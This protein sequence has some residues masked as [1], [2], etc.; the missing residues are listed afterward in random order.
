MMRWFCIIVI[1]LN[2]GGAV[3][4]LLRYPDVPGFT[5]L[6][7]A[8]IM[9]SIVGLLGSLKHARLTHLHSVEG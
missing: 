8:G 2:A 1:V 9:A 5:W 4:G 6:Y 7:L 3:M